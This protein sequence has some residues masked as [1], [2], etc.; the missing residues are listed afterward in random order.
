M[1]L[2]VALTLALVT[3]AWVPTAPARR[4]TARFAVVA[5]TT[6]TFSGSAPRLVHCDSL[7]KS[8]DSKRYQFR[9]ISLGVA[10]GV[11]PLQL[12]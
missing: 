7:S 1:R 5:S 3:H 2:V 9:D 4:R 11:T 12:G 8:Y 10:A 6:D